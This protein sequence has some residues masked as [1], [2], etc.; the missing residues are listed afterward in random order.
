MPVNFYIL[1]SVIDDLPDGQSGYP[2]SVE[3]VTFVCKLG[4]ATL[5]PTNGRFTW[6]NYRAHYCLD[7]FF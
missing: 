2:R 7:C 1:D 6:C 4:L 5:T 3:F